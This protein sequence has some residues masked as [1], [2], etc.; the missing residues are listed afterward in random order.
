MTE[1][2]DVGESREDLSDASAVHLESFDRP[3]AGGDG[4]GEAVGDLIL[5]HVAHDVELRDTL[6]GD[7]LVCDPFQLRVELLKEIFEK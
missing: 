5:T 1:S 3:V 7:G 4:V 6:L 2:G